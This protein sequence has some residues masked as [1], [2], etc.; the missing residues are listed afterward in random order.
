MSSL[1][2]SPVVLYCVAL[3]ALACSVD[4]RQLH[5][6]QAGDSA[7][8]EAGSGA[9]LGSSDGGGGAAPAAA[10]TGGSAGT[11]TGMEPQVGPAVC[12][13][14]VVDSDEECD[15]GAQ[16]VLDGCN[17]ACERESGY[18]CSGEPS[19]CRS[20]SGEAGRRRCTIAGGTFER[21]AEGERVPAA[22]SAFRLDELEV[23]VAR[24]RP[25]VAGFAGPPASGVGAH[26]DVPN[27]GW[28]SEWDGLFPASRE[29]LLQ[30][31]HCNA[32]WETWTDE[33]GARESYPITCVSYYVAFAFCAAEGG[34]LPTEAE[35]EYAATGG[36]QQRPYPW[37]DS[38]PSPE[39]AL[40]DTI[41]VEPAGTRLPGMARFG[42]LDLAG[43]VWEW[44]LDFFAPY[45]ADCDR[46]AAV[47][48]GAA[49]VLRGGDFLG[50]AEYLQT[51]YRFSYDPQLAL[52]NVGFR[53]AYALEE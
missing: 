25:F 37:G 46:C 8:S 10:G 12:G 50:D 38:Q 2:C 48:N 31:L 41:A 34:R 11:T 7:Q 3:G 17:S 19:S 52:G 27:S 16:A 13:D 39:L 14:G 23:T 53:C 49:R 45:P 51:A 4:Q 40:F 1:S 21:G 29:L 24:L 18:E 26:A 20:C 36:K 9:T 22:V 6:G 44:T 15:D 43:S 47:D 28:R 30:S 35:W 33:P 32:N 42:Q 5:L